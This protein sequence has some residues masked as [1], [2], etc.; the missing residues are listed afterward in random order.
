MRI[1][2]QLRTREQGFTLVELSI[3]LV[4]IGLIIGGILVGQ[5]LINSA[6]VRSTITQVNKYNSAINAFRGKYQYLPGDILAAR[7][8]AFGFTAL[9]GTDGLGDGDRQL[10]GDGGVVNTATTGDGE[11]TLFWQHLSEA[12]LI[13]GRI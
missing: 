7:A 10:E 13:D 3:V 6:E 1:N 5:E 8:T 2:P 4:I 12:E 9:A 11:V